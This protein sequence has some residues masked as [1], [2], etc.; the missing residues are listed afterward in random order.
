MTAARPAVSS[1][2]TPSATTADRQLELHHHHH[3][4]VELVVDPLAQAHAADLHH[5]VAT[6]CR[7]RAL[8]RAERHPGRVAC[9]DGNAGVYSPRAGFGIVTAQ[10]AIWGGPMRVDGGVE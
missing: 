7:L 5:H 9:D 3:G 8:E 10:L 1:R 2:T 6:P 4:G